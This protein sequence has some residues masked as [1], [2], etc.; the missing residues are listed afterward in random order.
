MC[1]GSLICNQLRNVGKTTFIVQKVIEH[2]LA[3][4]EQQILLAI[5]PQN[6]ILNNVK[7]PTNIT[8]L[9]TKSLNVVSDHFKGSHY[10]VVEIDHNIKDEALIDQYRTILKQKDIIDELQNELLRCK[11]KPDAIEILL[12]A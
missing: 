4:P 1:V 2:A 9:K 7:L 10:T 3:H 5:S 12:K 11:Q 6:P 8:V